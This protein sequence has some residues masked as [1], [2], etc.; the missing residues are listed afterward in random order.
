[1]CGDLGPAIGSQS[2]TVFISKGFLGVPMSKAAQS[3]HDQ[4]GYVGPLDA[5]CIVSNGN[6]YFLEWSPRLGWD[7]FY[8]LMNL[9]EGSIVDFFNKLTGS[10]KTGFSCSQRLSIPPY[11]Y[12]A[13]DLLKNYAHE[14]LI[15]ED[16]AKKPAFW[17]QDVYY[18]G[19]YRVAG[20]DGI[21]GVMSGVG[22]SIGAAYGKVYRH[23]DRFKI[24]S[25]KQYRTDGA[26]KH[27]ARYNELVKMKVV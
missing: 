19:Q 22:E 11:P 8:N 1:M 12:A 17:A 10:F 5:N 20:S 6:P 18:D 14:V 23:L 15:D 9:Y 3:L 16:L 26:K 13:G 27:E 2:N 25:Y 24:A 4:S 7:A 21:V